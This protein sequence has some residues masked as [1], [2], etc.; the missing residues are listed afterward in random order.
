MRFRSVYFVLGVLILAGGLG[1][2]AVAAEREQQ[3]QRSLAL[4]ADSQ[5]HVIESLALQTRTAALL[6]ARNGAF[7]AFYRAPGTLEEKM[8][9]EQG[10]VGPVVDALR[11]LQQIFPDSIRETCLID[12]SGREIAQVVRGRVTPVALL[13]DDEDEYDFFRPS[14]AQQFGRVYRS[15]PYVSSATKEWVFT[16]TAKVDAG[17]GV[18]PAIV[19][20]ELTVES[21]RL[22]LAK[23][24]YVGETRVL[25]A[26]TGA[27]VIDSRIPQDIGVPLGVPGE[28]ILPANRPLVDG[29][30]WTARDRRFLVRV[31]QLGAG[32]VNRWIVVS[33]VPEPTTILGTWPGG[34][35]FVALV[36]GLLLVIAV[37]LQFRYSKRLYRDAHLDTLT[38]LANRAELRTKADRLLARRRP[39]AVLLIDLDRFKAVNDTLGHHAGDALLKQVAE[40]INGQLRSPADVAGRFGGDE[41]VVLA[42]DLPGDPAGCERLCARLLAAISE[43]FDV[44]D[45]SVTVGASI[46]VALSPEHGSDFATLLRCAD[47]AMYD[48][49]RLELGWQLYRRDLADRGEY[50]LALQTELRRGIAAD[51]LVLHYQPCFRAVSGALTR[52]EALVR[53][54]HPQRGMLSPD[55]FIPLAE[56]SGAIRPLTRW[57]VR[58]ALTDAVA[59]RG[60]TPDLQVAVNVSV[61]DL[62]DPEFAGMVERELATRSLPGRALCIEITETALLADA[63]RAIRTLERLSTCGVQIA[64]DDFGAGYA[65]LPYLRQFPATLLKLDR[66]LIRAVAE[67]DGDTAVLGATIG[68]AHSMG[69][70][71]VAEGIETPAIL[72]TVVALGCDEVQGFHLQRPAPL[73][74]LLPMLRQHRDDGLSRVP[75][76]SPEAS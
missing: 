27:V 12:A 64:I 10:L 35:R 33:S 29:L 23:D 2:G 66:S 30:T 62:V 56:V 48:A 19:Q 41:F 70:A 14:F 24:P 74:E 7:A 25:D 53:W 76:G 73:T 54:Q 9:P 4:G 63:E 58:R 55:L 18:A 60:V 50:D 38:R 42:P 44:A 6:T 8:D 72:E 65:S 69:L 32:D 31:P 17:P 21:I 46:G 28:R 3:T 75:A 43:P 26:E 13:D 36:G 52:V 39:L 67:I 61:R 47:M 16:N 11:Y 71:V 51:E 5:V 34:P 49:K 22:E 68:L 45:V 40:R 57:V 1:L 20:F 59:A 37:G 15:A